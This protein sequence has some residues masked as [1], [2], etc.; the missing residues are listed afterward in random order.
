[1][2]KYEHIYNDVLADIKA[3]KL[4]PGDRL[5]TEYELCELYNVSRITVNRALNELV[6]AGV[7][8]RRPRSGS[9]VNKHTETASKKIAYMII[10]HFRYSFNVNCFEAFS[11]F[12][13]SKGISS[14]AIISHYKSEKYRQIIESLNR[15]DVLGIAV[16]TSPHNFDATAQCSLTNSFPRAAI[17]FY[18]D[19]DGFSGPRIIVDE[20]E[21]AGQAVHYLYNMGHRNFAYCGALLE[22]D[23]LSNRL[24]YKGFCDACDQLGLPESNR[25]MLAYQDA[26]TIHLFKKVFFGE[27]PPTCIVTCSEYYAMMAF[28]YL[29]AL[30]LRVPED[31]AIITLDGTNISVAASVPFTSIEFDAERIGSLVAE[32]LWEITC[33]DKP[34]TSQLI[35]IPSRLVV[36]DSCG[37]KNEVYRHEYIRPQLTP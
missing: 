37:N 23:E 10:S 16:Q 21:A 4:C 30:K 6:K 32:N 28:D 34:M 15:S 31:V 27:N 3:G 35:R 22:L 25:T 5:P 26:I 33:C 12:F 9:F 14:A 29:T 8:N 13:D 20:E 2:K 24:R 18:R 11:K 17:A 1:M 7:V 36:R 19:L